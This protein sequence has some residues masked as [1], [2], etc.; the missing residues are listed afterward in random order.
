MNINKRLRGTT[1]LHMLAYWG[2]EKGAILALE[3]GA[4]PTLLDP[5]LRFPHAKVRGSMRGKVSK[6]SNP[7]ND[8]SPHFTTDPLPDCLIIGET[9]ATREG[10]KNVC[11]SCSRPVIQWFII[12]GSQQPYGYIY[13]ATCMT[14][15]C[16]QIT[17]FVNQVNSKNHN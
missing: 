10:H 4:D 9:D 14:K 3:E 8:E 7:M 6:K 15:H 12:R 17:N 16:E 11:G 13:C 5:Q 1:L 2:W